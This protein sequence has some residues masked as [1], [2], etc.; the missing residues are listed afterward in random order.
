VA[1]FL[2]GMIPLQVVTVEFAVD[3]DSCWGQKNT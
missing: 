1:V 3:L 2:K